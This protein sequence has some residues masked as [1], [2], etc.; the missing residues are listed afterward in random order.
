MEQ[1]GLE[2]FLEAT[3]II[4]DLFSESEVLYA[5]YFP[6]P[7]ENGDSIQNKPVTWFDIS[8]IKIREQETNLCV[9]KFQISETNSTKR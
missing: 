1:E 8:R 6:D 7:V 4:Y 5:T 9:I 2:A 3:E